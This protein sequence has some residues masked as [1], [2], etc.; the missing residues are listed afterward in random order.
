MQL[1]PPDKRG[2]QVKACVTL[3]YT[4]LPNNLCYPETGTGSVDWEQER[5]Y[6]SLKRRILIKDL[7]KLT[8][9][10]FQIV[11]L[12]KFCII[13]Y[14]YPHHMSK[15]SMCHKFITKRVQPH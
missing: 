5:W 11:I 15:K 13:I 9:D 2:S 14:C 1:V 6:Q 12:T 4:P 8:K 10:N 3:S 7:I